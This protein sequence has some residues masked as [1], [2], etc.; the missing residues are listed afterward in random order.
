MI[1]LR[2][3][4]LIAWAVGIYF[5]VVGGPECQASTMGCRDAQVLG[6]LAFSLFALVVLV[7]PWGAKEDDRRA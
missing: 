7:T 4:T 5:S 2:I 3:V 6:V 1:A